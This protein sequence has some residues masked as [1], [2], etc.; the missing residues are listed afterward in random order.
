[1]CLK[2][3]PLDARN[4]PERYVALSYVWG[5][6]IT[7]EEVYK[8]VM[9]NVM[10]H[11]QHGGIEKIWD[12][13]PRTI[14][15]AILLVGRLGER[16]IWIDSLCIVQDS[17]SSWEL[18]AR[19]MHLV[20][21]NAYLT[22]CA[23][24]GDAET[25]LLAVEPMLQPI[26]PASLGHPEA[27]NK[28]GFEILHR[29]LTAEC[30]P[31]VSLLVSRSPEATI[32]DSRWNKRGWTF[33]ERLLSRRCLVFADGHVYFQ[34]RSSVM[35]QDV[36]TDG[37]T[38]GWSLEWTNSP[39]RTMGELN[40]RAFWFYMRCIRLY[41]GREL[42]KPRDILTAFQGTSWL[43]QQRLNSPLLFG[44]PTSHF[45]LALLWSPV[46]AL[47]RRKKQQRHQLNTNTC[48]QD[49]LGNCNC[50]H[51]EEDYG[52]KEFP[53]WSWCGWIGGKSE[54][55]S[56]MIEA[57]L[58]DVRE[59]LMGHTWILWHFRDEEGNL[60]PLWDKNLLMGDNSEEAKWRGY[61]GQGGS[62]A[63]SK[64]H[65]DDRR[66][67]TYTNRTPCSIGTLPL[68]G[69]LGLGLELR[70]IQ[71]TLIPSTQGL[72]YGHRHTQVYGRRKTAAMNGQ[73]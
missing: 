5:K 73:G 38:G 53:S 50:R 40:R 32:Q 43:L 60:R 56:D 29:P 34:C 28:D 15:H 52:K 19:A 11:I 58:L 8:T 70:M 69:R 47:R 44:L 36:Y 4:K 65:G 33:Q 20:Y 49:E 12:K 10:L 66:Y 62:P 64:A 51:Y 16:Y 48:S 23:A 30:V 2:E 54:Y 9:S 26:I 39:L 67:S 25:G 13:L 17:A 59:W 61:H 55:Q 7:G 45:D 1:M 3:L 24:D 22:I 21:G 27:I 41:T 71:G 72:M 68:K 37:G 18:N 14:Q 46:D 31:G 63:V 42:S 57:C 6:T 35:S